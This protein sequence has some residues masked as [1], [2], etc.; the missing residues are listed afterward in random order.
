I[1][2]RLEHVV[3][4]SLAV[5]PDVLC[6]QE[7]KCV[8]AKFPGQKLRAAGFEY[9]EHFGEKAYNGVAILSKTPLDD[10]ER[11]FPD[12]GEN[13]PRRLIAAT[14]DGIRIVNVYL[15]HG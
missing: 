5:R 15:P 8:D 13:A 11:N 10:V 9:I 2:S 12:D 6:L 7:T 3:K 4:W 1:N 14:T